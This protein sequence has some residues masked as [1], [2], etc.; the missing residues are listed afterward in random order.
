MKEAENFKWTAYI[1]IMIGTLLIR[2]STF[3]F[4]PFKFHSTTLHYASLTSH[5][6]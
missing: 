3:H 4:F 2:H 5:L 1:L 6:T